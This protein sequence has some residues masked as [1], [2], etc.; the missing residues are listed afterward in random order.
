M[1]TQK[2]ILFLALCLMLGLSACAQTPI[3]LNGSAWNLVEL[4]GQPVLENS[5]PTLVFEADRAGGNGSCNSIGGEYQSENGKL[6]F[7]P[8]ISTMMYC[9][10]L[11]DQEMAYL[12]AL[13]T[14][15]SYQVRDNNLQILNADGQ[16]ILIFMP[17]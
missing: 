12:K 9:E 14:A 1:K 15:A 7:G 6:S 2:T 16:V 11:M 10:G 4:N 5:N 8:M 17:Q 3:D 13:E